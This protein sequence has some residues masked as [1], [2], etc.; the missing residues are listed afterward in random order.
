[1]KKIYLYVICLM[2]AITYAQPRVHFYWGS[3]KSYGAEVMFNDFSGIGFSGTADSYTGLGTYYPGPIESM[4][5]TNEVSTTTRKWFTLYAISPIYKIEGLESIDFSWDV[6]LAM[7]G[8]HI[9]F[10]D[11][12]N[13]IFYHKKTNSV[14]RPMIGL[15][16][17]LPIT[18]D[19]G[20]QIGVDS[21]S[22]FTTGFLVYF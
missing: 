14:Y 7:Y 19:I 10:Y 22:Y 4:F 20:W 16:I 11:E 1:M 3:S 18:K 9:N 6:G 15:N 17:S 5:D 8:R 21:F 13:D 12:N 2:S